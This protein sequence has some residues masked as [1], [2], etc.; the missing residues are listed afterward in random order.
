MRLFD[1]YSRPGSRVA[2]ALAKY[3]ITAA[4][5]PPATCIIQ[6]RWPLP[7]PG[8]RMAVTFALLTQLKKILYSRALCAEFSMSGL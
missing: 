3:L 5:P 7:G 8:V 2:R 6:V 1:I 4:A